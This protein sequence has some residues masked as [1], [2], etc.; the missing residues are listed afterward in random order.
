MVS[1]SSL[2]LF[3][4]LMF[5]NTSLYFRTEVPISPIKDATGLPPALPPKRSR[6]SSVKSAS[7]PP[8]SS[9][10]PPS[11][12]QVLPT[13]VDTEPKKP[14]EPMEESNPLEQLDI[15]KYLVMKK[16]DEEGPDVRGGHPD[17]LI[18]HATKA[19]KNGE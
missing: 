16:A 12:H 13:E 18:I 14:S 10:P 2:F 15:S 7:S 3:I 1:F 9:P 6:T 19:N 11:R 17:A 8:P 4:E 5:T